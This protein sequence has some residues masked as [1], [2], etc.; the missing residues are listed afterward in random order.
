MG[1]SCLHVSDAAIFLVALRGSVFSVVNLAQ[2][3]I[4]HQCVASAW[5]ICIIPTVA[6]S[7]D[8]EETA[9]K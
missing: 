3:A 2:E 4:A 8:V 1:F 6:V 5:S 9:L 7:K